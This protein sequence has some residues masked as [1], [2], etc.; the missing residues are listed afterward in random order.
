MPSPLGRSDVRCARCHD[1][2]ATVRNWPDRSNR[3]ALL[4]CRSRIDRRGESP[5]DSNI[6]AR[7]Q[8]PKRYWLRP[9][10]SF[11]GYP[12]VFA[13][14]IHSPAGRSDQ[15]PPDLGFVTVFQSN[16]L[17][18]D[19]SEAVRPIASPIRVATDKIRML[20]A[21]L[22]ALVGWIESVMTSSLSREP[23]MRA[24]APPDSTPWVM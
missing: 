16:R 8:P 11:R 7:F 23:A 12:G 14:F 5:S 1:F 9:Q 2:D 17:E 10:A 20:R 15:G 24:T 6:N 3:D 13:R 19:S 21:P 22:T 18:T 4:A